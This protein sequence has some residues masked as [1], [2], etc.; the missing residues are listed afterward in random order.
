MVASRFADPTTTSRQARVRREVVTGFTRERYDAAEYVT[1]ESLAHAVDG[2]P[3]ERMDGFDAAFRHFIDGPDAFRQTY[4]VSG[5]V[6]R[7]TGVTFGRHT[8]QFQTYQQTHRKLLVTPEEEEA[9]ESMA[10]S[11]YQSQAVCSL[12]DRGYRDLC[13]RGPV[14][15]TPCQAMPWWFRERS[16]TVVELLTV[17]PENFYVCEFACHQAMRLAFT[18]ALVREV[19][20]VQPQVF[21]ICVARRH[22]WAATVIHVD[23]DVLFSAEQTIVGGLNKYRKLTQQK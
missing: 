3:I 1:V 8:T 14:Y 6:N 13:I 23:S 19:L 12:L 11:M 15:G 22:P 17:D 20:E 5:P 18:R 7:S 4:D 16:Q 2:T 9:I 10:M 21:V